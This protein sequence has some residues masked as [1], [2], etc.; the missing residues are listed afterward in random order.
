[1]FE[2]GKKFVIYGFRQA[3]TLKFHAACTI[4]RSQDEIK[5]AELHPLF[6][7]AFLE[8][9]KCLREF[10]TIEMNC[11][12]EDFKGKSITEFYEKNSIAL[13]EGS[14]GKVFQAKRKYINLRRI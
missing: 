5:L 6:E 9:K 8:A 10:S 4:F 3:A 2:V 7:Q 12:Q 13:G 1:L 14:F 11:V